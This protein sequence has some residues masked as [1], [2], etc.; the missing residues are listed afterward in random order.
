VTE[1][2]TFV[3]VV[4]EEAGLSCASTLHTGGVLSTVTDVVTS[5]ACATGTP[6]SKKAT[7][8]NE[9]AIVTAIAVATVTFPASI[10]RTTGTVLI[11]LRRAVT[12]QADPF[13]YSL[14]V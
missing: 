6:T 8:P 3:G 2:P 12:D 5:S 14:V 9:N 1:D 11:V 4:V 10:E 13:Q 7:M